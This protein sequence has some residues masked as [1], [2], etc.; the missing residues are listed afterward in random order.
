MN[1]QQTKYIE[2]LEALEQ[3]AVDLYES[4]KT[5]KRTMPYAA[6]ELAFEMVR[7]LKVKDADDDQ[8]FY[9]KKFNLRIRTL[10]ALMVS[11]AWVTSEI[12]RH[13]AMAPDSWRDSA[14][15]LQ[16]ENDSE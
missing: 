14:K 1:D 8:M 7:G 15:T 3:L 9:Y 16:D 2:E 6:S 13:K 5:A 10:V 11:H 12:E 4:V